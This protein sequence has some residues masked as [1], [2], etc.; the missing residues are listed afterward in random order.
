MGNNMFQ[1]AAAY[2]YCK[3]YGYRLRIPDKPCPLPPNVAPFR[4]PAAAA[5]A[6]RT[7]REPHYHY[8]P[9]PEGC[10]R[11]TG[12]FQ[13]S[14]YFSSCADEIRALFAPTAETTAHI[15]DRYGEIIAQKDAVIAIHVRRGDYVNNTGHYV[16]RST[17]YYT[18]AIE[19]IIRRTGNSNPRLC[20]VSDDIAWCKSQP[21]FADAFFLE[22]SD[23]LLSLYILG[24]F[25]HFIISNSS[26]SWWAVFLANA[27]D[28]V[29]V[30]PDRWTNPCLLTD[31]YD[32]FEPTWVRI[33]CG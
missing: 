6:R 23:P 18:S 27:P 20:I 4:A 10:D 30:S 24:S 29:V 5:P 22:E 28:G 7:W 21:I 12:Y 8:Q 14:K 16:I 25:K 13:S 32:V 3:Q 17:A 11:L 1:I 33:P 2:A 31:D 9:I 15:H 26:Y 19:E